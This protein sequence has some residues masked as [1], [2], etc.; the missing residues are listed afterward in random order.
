MA[1]YPEDQFLRAAALALPADEA[2][3]LDAP[4]RFT[5]ERLASARLCRERLP[6]SGEAH[7]ELHAF[8][9][10]CWEALDGLAREANVCMH[11]LSP[12]AGL[13]PPLE[14]SRQCSL[15]VLRQKLHESPQT[16][17]HP[18]SELLWRETREAPA[19]ECARLS[20]LYNLSLFMPLPI[21]AEGTLPGTGD[22]PA[23]ALRIVKH[24]AVERCDMA[25]GLD[26]I[27]H[28]L[29]SLMAECY[30]LLAEAMGGGARATR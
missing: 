12:D 22:V 17:A 10:E 27:L 2:E 18:M 24:Q 14:M 23:C 13:H 15:Y 25:Y 21:P 7:A 28:W 6:A 16:A 9:R 19:P 11:R 30:R 8:L 5:Q 29:E 4:H 20:F 26:A 3:L 1:E